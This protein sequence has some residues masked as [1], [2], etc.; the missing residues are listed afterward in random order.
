VDLGQGRPLGT[1]GT[2]PVSTLSPGTHVI[3][4][5]VRDS[6][7]RTADT[8]IAITINLAPT[9]GITGPANLAVYSPGDAVGFSGTASDTEDGDMT[10]RIMWD[11]NRDGHLGDGGS[12]SVTTLTSGTHV[13]T[14]AIVDNGGARKTAQVSVVVNAAPT[15]AI[16]APTTLLFGHGEAITFTANAQDL[17]DGNRSSTVTWSSSVDG[18]LPSGASITV[19]SLS[20][21]LHT[22]TAHVSDT[23]GKTADATLGLE[24]NSAPVVAISAPANNAASTPGAT[25]TFAASANDFE[26]GDLS[27]SIDWS[28]SVEGPIGHGASIN[29]SSLRS[30]T[31]PRDRARERRPRPAG[32]RAGHRDRQRRPD[33]RHHQPVERDGLFPDR[34]GLV[35]GDR[36]RHG[37]RQHR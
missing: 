10:S 28:S 23:Q 4:A 12:I 37:G 15:I 20:S 34:Y 29:V 1:G 5:S 11:S 30:G 22:I 33:H 6:V 3:T 24:V 27:A 2:L 21:G 17:E 7:G 36:H 14:A 25:I 32:Q 31:T 19:S 26:Q 35:R 9:I 16:T 18:P 13:V 8:S